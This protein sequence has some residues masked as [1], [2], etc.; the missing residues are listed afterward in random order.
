MIGLLKRICVGE[1]AGSRSVGRPRKRRIN[2]VEDWL[3]KRGLDIRQPRRMVQDMSEWRGFCE[4]EYIRHS[5]GDEPQTLTTCHSCGLP[6]LCE[7]LEVWK[8]V[9]GRSY[10]LKGIK[11]T[12]SLFLLFLNLCFSFTVAHLMV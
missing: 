6:H 2:T 11:G 7:A 4:G 5:P 8:S 12:V 9:C 3:R 1:C 10:N